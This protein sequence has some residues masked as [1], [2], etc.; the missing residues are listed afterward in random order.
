MGQVMI[1]RLWVFLLFLALAVFALGMTG[2]VRPVSLK[3]TLDD[4][5]YEE[6]YVWAGKTFDILVAKVTIQN[7]GTQDIAIDKAY[8]VDGDEASYNG[9]LLYVDWTKNACRCTEVTPSYAKIEKLMPEDK[10]GG[11][12]MAFQEVPKDVSRL[13]LMIETD[14]GVAS[15]AL[16]STESARVVGLAGS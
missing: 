1:K 15:L 5:Y 7:S 12:F 3:V 16:G 11:Y 6:Y 4:L 8:L 9:L 2:C 13:K 14:E 10:T